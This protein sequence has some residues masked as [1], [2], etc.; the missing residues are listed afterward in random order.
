MIAGSEISVKKHLIFGKP[1]KMVEYRNTFQL[2]H[3][4]LNMYETREEAYDFLLKFNDPV[5]VSMISGKKIMH[6]HGCAP[7]DFCPG[8]TIIMPAGE[9]MKIDFPEASPQQ[10]TR[11]MALN[12]S[13]E[14]IS[15][16]M[17]LLNEH[18][19]RS[20]T[21]DLWKWSD[22]N[23]H[24]M[25]SPNVAQTIGRL[26]SLFSENQY[27]KDILAMH[28]TRELV[29]QLLQ[30]R[31]QYLLV[32]QPASMARNH[33]LGFVIDYIRQNLTGKLTIEELAE[34]AC[35][36]RAQFFRV[37]QRELGMSP[38]RFINEERLKLA[39]TLMR[40]TRRSISEICFLTGFNNLNYFSRIFKQLMRMSP[41]EYRKKLLRK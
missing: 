22:E 26:I 15:E 32:E 27:G 19:P 29:I 23:F 1:D 35:L 4:E 8:E 7:F 6:L 5:V 10:P 33:R 20:E 2:D 39:K 13:R 25:N 31:A 21:R 3:A 37:F 40:D 28:T 38:V 9:L 24:M 41:S 12:I 14:F 36:S 16:T 34:K 17:N 30:T 18:Y 11:C